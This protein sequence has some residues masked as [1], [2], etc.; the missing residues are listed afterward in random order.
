MAAS[1]QVAWFVLPAH[2]AKFSEPILAVL[3]RELAPYRRVLDPCAGI[4]LIHSAAP[5]A[6]A[7]EIEP[8]WA[9]QCDGPTVV[10]DAQH[11][12][13]RDLSFD[14]IATSPTYGNRM[15]DHH[16]ARDGSRRITYRHFLDRPLHPE[17]TGRLQWGPRYQEKHLAIWRECYRVLCPGGVFILNISDH[18]RAGQVVPVAAWHIA[19]MTRVGFL[20]RRQWSVET[21]RMRYGAN[22]G[23]RVSHE[24]VL[25]F[26]KRSDALCL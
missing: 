26:T 8:E 2:P 22:S 13:F 5:T 1:D 19:T 10:S 3:R 25:K 7:N 9:E 16:N 17:N 15:A 24:Y 11:L 6:V 14:A 18:I 12:P 4:G 21:Q 20:L 23:Q